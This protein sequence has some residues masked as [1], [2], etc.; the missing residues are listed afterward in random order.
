ML[1]SLT[2]FVRLQADCQPVNS[3]LEAGAQVQQTIALEALSDFAETPTLNISF[4]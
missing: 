4:K 3:T 2:N 1:R